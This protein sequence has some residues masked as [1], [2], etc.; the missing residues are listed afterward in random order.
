[1][2]NFLASLCTLAALLTVETILACDRPITEVTETRC[3]ECPELQEFQT[4]PQRRI[5]NHQIVLT[6]VDSTMLQQNYLIVCRRVVICGNRPVPDAEGRGVNRNRPDGPG[7]G[8]ECVKNI[9]QEVTIPAALKRE[10]EHSVSDVEVDDPVIQ[11]PFSASSDFDKRQPQV[12]V[13][14][15]KL[16]VE[17]APP[18]TMITVCQRP[19]L[20]N[21][22]CHPPTEEKIEPSGVSLQSG[23]DEER[24]SGELDRQGLI[25]QSEPDNVVLNGTLS[26]YP[27]PS[28]G[29][30]SLTI[31]HEGGGD[32][33]ILVSDLRGSAI[34]RQVIDG[35]QQQIHHPLRLDAPPGAYM[36][37]VRSLHGSLVGQSI[38]N[39]D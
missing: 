39:V 16:E 26:A 4:V 18:S 33:E 14:V 7:S 36:V 38:I 13:E 24:Q 37:T 29:Q 27:N 35:E 15:N 2:K 9:R 22:P 11:Y 8:R 5:C 23:G 6:T 34:Y 1:M 25:G 21:T 10:I 30:L 32:L 19:S 3:S 20:R 28:Q 17:P 31:T 12:F